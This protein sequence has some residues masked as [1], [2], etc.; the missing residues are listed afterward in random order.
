M[1]LEISVK[2]PST[3]SILSMTEDTFPSIIRNDA[4]L[5][6]ISEVVNWLTKES[7]VLKLGLSNSGTVLFRGFPIFTPEDFDSFSSAFN[8]GNFTYQESLSNAVRINK[9]PR[10]FTAN[11]A[12]PEV[13]IFLHHEMA[14]TPSYPE[15]I[16]FCC[17]SPAAEGGATPLCRSDKVYETLNDKHP[18]WVSKFESLGLKYT[19][20][21]PNSD[22]LASGQ[23]RGWRSTLSVQDKKAAEERLIELNYTWEWQENGSLLAT[24]PP[25]PATTKLTDGKI[26]FFNQIIAAYR[27]WKIQENMSL[28]AVT[29]GNGE[30]IDEIILNTISDIAERFTTALEWEPGDVALVDN[31]RVMHGRNPYSGNKKREVVVCLAR[32]S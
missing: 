21:M 13:E 12:P 30:H 15:K 11:E 23:G 31:K 22:E 7:S 1:I 28:P 2:V 17:L 8:Y 5:N 32:D 27:G 26:S 25:L 14:Q 9:T 19:T 29:F 18:K 16:F 20:L 4:G 6:N 10:V 24:T 3:P